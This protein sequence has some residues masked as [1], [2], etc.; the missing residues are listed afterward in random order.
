M[1][2]AA[3]AHGWERHLSFEGG[4]NGAPANGPTGFGRNGAFTGTHYSSDVA[5]SGAQSARFAIERGMKGF[6]HWGATLR[7][8]QALHEEDELWVLL[9][10]YL[11]E[12]FDFGS[13]D[14][15]L[16]LLRL[17]MASAGGKPQGFV[18]LSIVDAGRRLA[19]VRAAPGKPVE[20]MERPP[21][22]RGKPLERGRWHAI[23]LHVRL[24]SKGQAGRVQVWHDASLVAEHRHV[25]L[26]PGTFSRMDHLFLFGTW[27]GGAPRTQSAYV[28]DLV[29][30]SDRPKQ[31]DRRGNARLWPYG[32]RED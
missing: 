28:D 29:L 24:A 19:I 2:V 26:L 7:F 11:P 3:A 32:S 18:G 6:G 27:P 17:H 8:P 23:E 1:A 14:H 5:H 21:M 4:R 15:D 20:R 31:R 30:T 9:H 10:L 12:S 22:S 16:P 25:A 13:P